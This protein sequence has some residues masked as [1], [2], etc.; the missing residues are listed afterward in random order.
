[1]TDIGHEDIGHE[2][3][4]PDARNDLRS[5]AESLA[6][7]TRDLPREDPRASLEA[8]VDRGATDIVG[9]RWASVTVLRHGRFQTVASNSPAAVT[10]DHVQYELGTGPCVDAVLEDATFVTGDV[11]KDARWRPMAERVNE[12]F[13]VTSML[14]YRLH[15]LD[16]SETIAGL[17]FS[18]DEPDAFSEADLHRGLVFATHC[19]LLVTASQA[20]DKAGHLLR[21]LESNREIGVAVGI[22]MAQHRLTR[23]QAFD[24][25]RLASQRTNRKLVDVASDVAD[26]GAAPGPIGKDGT[27]G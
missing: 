13:G 4:G 27:I 9:A 26:T 23:E 6:R 15:L 25:L 5:T 22:L 8:L 10:I 16:E 1:M 17:N 21:A 24:V 20:H 11:T 3:V 7:L 2:D 18:T 19:A 14:A 12:L